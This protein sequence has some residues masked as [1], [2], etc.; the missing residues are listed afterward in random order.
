MQ[1]FVHQPYYSGLNSFAP[2]RASGCRI[3]GSGFGGT[4]LGFR[5]YRI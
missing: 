2:V 1:D 5:V 4:E 3:G